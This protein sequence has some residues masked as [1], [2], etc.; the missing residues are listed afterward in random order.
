[1]AATARIA[2]AFT[3]RPTGNASDDKRA[4]TLNTSVF[5]RNADPLKRDPNPTCM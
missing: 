3:A 1:M 4:T 2:V 5:V